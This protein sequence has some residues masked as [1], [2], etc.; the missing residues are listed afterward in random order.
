VLVIED[1]AAIRHGFET[2]LRSW[3][4][5]TLSADSGEA[6]LEYAASESWRSD[7][8][9]ADHRLGPGLTGVATAKE[10]ERR[11][12]RPIPTM[13]VTGDT[14]TERIT[15]INASGY[16]VLHKPVTPEDLRRALAQ[17]LRKAS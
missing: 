14:A 1:N 6:A 7:A 8:I 11:A 13:V 2:M 4:Y 3:G 16:V 12:G 17:L 9:L 10:M 5:E 15:E